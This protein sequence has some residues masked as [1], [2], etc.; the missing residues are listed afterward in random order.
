MTSAM[1]SWC[2]RLAVFTA[3]GRTQGM[4][5]SRQGR[6]GHLET[7][8]T[9]P[10]PGHMPFALYSAHYLHYVLRHH[11]DSI[12]S[13]A[14]SHFTNEEMMN[15]LSKSEGLAQYLTSIKWWR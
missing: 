5:N 12:W 11:H 15:C 7:A 10:F 9:L 4:S 14:V 2:H 6:W 8:A 13:L 1:P 3:E